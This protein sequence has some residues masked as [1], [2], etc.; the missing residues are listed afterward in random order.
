M[1]NDEEDKPKKRHRENRDESKEERKDRKE[2][3]K[4]RDSEMSNR[5]GEKTLRVHTDETP[6]IRSRAKQNREDSRM[7]LQ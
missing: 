2:N 7:E 4:A 1:G 6:R 3:K 5:N